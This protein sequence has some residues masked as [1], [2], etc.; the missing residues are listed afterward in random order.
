[1]YSFPRSFARVNAFLVTLLLA[2]TLARSV[3]GDSVQTPD[4][5]LNQ[6]RPIV[7]ILASDSSGITVEYASPPLSFQPGLVDG[8][9]CLK[10]ELE[11]FGN[12]A[13]PG[14]PILPI[15]GNLI[16]IPSEASLS[17]QALE[18]ET[19][20]LPLSLPLCPAA[21]FQVSIGPNGEMIS[22]D[23]APTWDSSPLSAA[24]VD[25]TAGFDL[26]PAGKIR[27]QSVAMLR[28]FPLQYD[29]ARSELRFIHRLVLRVDFITPPGRPPQLSA[30]LIPEGPFESILK[31]NLLNY[32]TALQWRAHPAR[33]LL[34]EPNQPQVTPTRFKI[35]VNQDGFY[36]LTY[37]ELQ[38]AGVPVDT[39]DPNRFQM[40][41]NDSG[42]F[43]RLLGIQ[44][45]AFNPGDSLLF[46]GQRL[47]SKYT[48]R[49]VYW[50]YE[51][52]T[53]GLRISEIDGAP[54]QP[55]AIPAQFQ[56][57]IHLEEDHIY[58][59][60]R[61]S[62][63]D[64]DHWYWA[65]LSASSAPVSRNF[66]FTL[67]NLA[68]DSTGPYTARLRALFH[69]YSASSN[70]R[71]RILINGAQI[72]DQTWPSGS[73]LS[74]DIPFP[75]AYLLEGQN[76]FTVEATY[77]SGITQQT[78][79]VNWFEID[80]FDSYTL[81]NDQLFFSADT[82][83]N[84]EFHLTGAITDTLEIYDVTVPTFPKRITGA[85]PGGSPGSY[86]FT[87]H[88][89]TWSAPPR[90][91]ALSPAN[92]LKPLQII[93]DDS[94][95]LRSVNNRA[96]YLVITHADFLPQ[97]QRLA[98]FR[99]SQGLRTLVVDVEDIYDLFG[100]G[101]LD[102]EAIRDFLAYAYQNWTPPAPSF[103][104]LFGD[105][106]YDYQNFFGYNQPIFIPPYLGDLDPYLGETAVDNR[107]VAISG[108]DPL[109]DMHIGRLPANSLAEATN[110]VD[111]IIA[112]ENNPLLL[113]GWHEK[114]TFVT[115]NPDSAGD[116]YAL[117]DAIS[118]G[119][120]PQNYQQEKIYLG[121]THATAAEVKST[122]LS[123]VN[124]GRLLVS[125]IGHASTSW[126]AYEKLLTKDDVPALTNAG[127]LAFFVPMTCLE[128]YFINPS[129]SSP[130]LAETL[131]RAQASGAIASW[132]P[133]GLG[134]ATGHDVLQRGL[135]TAL[136]Q[137][138]QVHLG[139][140]ASQ[141]KYYLYANSL[142]SHDLI[143]TYILLGDPATPLKTIDQAGSQLIRLPIISHP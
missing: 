29:P 48:D 1:M 61:P 67:H 15:S 142:G 51:D 139:A 119:Y 118:S 64:N 10:P 130:A 38:A 75:Q 12:N 99:A 135:F 115:D 107:L 25:P 50:L 137:D 31:D 27:S 88:H 43:I 86:E 2:G 128:G 33:T 83:D 140:A 55:A 102:P 81:E 109:P 56:T 11:G 136:F 111:K 131:V 112:Y 17:S 103:V 53:P 143:D 125:Y 97:A 87:F 101:D 138:R 46:Y 92:H 59:S 20:T 76:Q 82:P 122:L 6:P 93:A 120:L 117:S 40:S 13:L 129:S 124:Q 110:I 30:D 4:Q 91:L 5:E 18:I 9:E 54:G 116:F 52:I 60:S 85:V 132:S 42:I 104:V 70:Q 58:Q 26:A 28:F 90:Y 105:G 78:F 113:D 16:G 133:T 84:W 126:W 45:G 71:A 127:R 19:E 108:S 7:H 44:D 57:S 123:A 79:F 121:L 77:G 62:G 14:Q 74:L 95:G 3:Q 65:G 63:S 100:Q 8:Q 134:V 94:P 72:A 106:H 41:L 89:L 23:Q 24:P 114:V 35:L 80:Y 141:A 96:D 73:P 47:D 22:L 68:P 66:P 21:R 69:G 36:E 32:S 98:D 49:N 37:S 39:W 34:P